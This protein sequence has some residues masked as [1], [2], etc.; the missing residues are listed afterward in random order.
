MESPCEPTEE[1]LAKMVEPYL[2]A[3][4]RGLGF[5]IGHASPKF[6][7]YGRVRVFGNVQN[8]FGSGPRL[9]G[10]TPFEIASITKTFTA[11]L[12]DQTFVLP[13]KVRPALGEAGRVL[14]N[15][16]S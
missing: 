3:Q 15:T 10:E 6:E 7:N 16:N 14:E 8:Q 12:Y 5:A 13:K 1:L 9:S 2:C 4:R 11:T